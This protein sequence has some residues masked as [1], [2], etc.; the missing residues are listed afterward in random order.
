MLVPTIA[1]ERLRLRAYELADVPEL[2]R[3]IGVRE[4]A[5]NLLRVPY[6]YTEQDARNFILSR[7]ESGE[8]RFAITLAKEQKLIGGIGLRIHP[9]HP[10][11]ELGYWLG[12]PY[13]GCGYATEASRAVVNYGFETLGLH[14][15]YASA[16][17]DNVA[18]AKVLQRLG[19]Q[20]EGRLRE[21]VLKWG[22][23]IDLEVYGILRSQWK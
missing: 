3:L 14:R 2:A 21:H 13:W 19:M 7:R 16:F 20:H 4:V 18:S 12:R 11:A 17:R 10:R 8:A 1:T 22:R 9:Q 6:P 15:I 23:F 5:E